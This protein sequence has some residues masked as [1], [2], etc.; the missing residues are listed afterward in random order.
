MLSKLIMLITLFISPGSMPQDDAAVA[1]PTHEGTAAA[2]LICCLGAPAATCN[3]ASECAWD[4]KES[5]CL[6]GC[7][8]LSEGQC[9]AR[10]YC[11]FLGGEDDHCAPVNAA[12]CQDSGK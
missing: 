2:A 12:Q 10:S 5:M 4:D 7:R 11:V 6:S 3:A 8:D 9:N 1:P